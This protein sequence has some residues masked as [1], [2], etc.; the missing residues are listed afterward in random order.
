[1]P[2]RPA[3]EPQAAGNSCALAR[4]P[5]EYRTIAPAASL[6]D[7]M[8]GEEDGGAFG[9]RGHERFQQFFDRHGIETFARL[10]ED[11]ELWTP[12]QCEHQRELRAHPLRQRLDLARDRQIEFAE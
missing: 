9:R 12:R 8:R 6:R 1:M 2:N 4:M 7:L 11:Q 5:T 3:A 10:V